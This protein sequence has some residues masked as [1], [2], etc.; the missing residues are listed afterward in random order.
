MPSFAT[1]MSFKAVIYSKFMFYFTNF[2]SSSITLLFSNSLFLI[3]N[4]LLIFWASLIN[5]FLQCSLFFQ[6]AESL[7][8]AFSF[9]YNPIFFSISPNTRFSTSFIFIFRES[10][11]QIGSLTFS[12]TYFLRVSINYSKIYSHFSLITKSQISLTLGTLSSL[13]KEIYYFRI[14]Q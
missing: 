4:C 8:S 3:F 14:R 11:S 13:I 1:E 5:Y 2:R 7:L 6:R 9:F 10:S 12:L